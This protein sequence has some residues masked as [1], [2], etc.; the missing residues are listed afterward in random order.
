M[1]F[2]DKTARL[3]SAIGHL[4][5][6]YNLSARV[7]FLG[8]CPTGYDVCVRDGYWI[9]PLISGNIVPGMYCRGVGLFNSFDQSQS[10]AS[11]IARYKALNV[12]LDW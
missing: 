3:S 2:E 7:F 11:L 12:V 10:S 1:S 9:E 6:P 4:A 8:A 5:I